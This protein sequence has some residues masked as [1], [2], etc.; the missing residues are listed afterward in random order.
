M[1]HIIDIPRRE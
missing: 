1:Q